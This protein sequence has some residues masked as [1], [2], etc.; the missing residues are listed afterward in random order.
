MCEV[1]AAVM[2]RSGD[3][4]LSTLQLV[5]IIAEVRGALDVQ[6]GTW[7]ATILTRENIISYPGMLYAGEQVLLYCLDLVCA[8]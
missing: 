1:E 5:A 2:R 3:K 8:E 4:K 6:C 7:W